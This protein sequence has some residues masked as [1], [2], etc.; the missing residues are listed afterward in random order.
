[1]LVILFTWGGG[2]NV[3]STESGG[4]VISAEQGQLSSPPRPAQLPHVC[5]A[6]EEQSRAPAWA[7]NA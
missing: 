4:K 1:M 6:P 3:Q 2:I 5:A 7:E